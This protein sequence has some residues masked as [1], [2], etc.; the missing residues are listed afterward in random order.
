LDESLLRQEIVGNNPRQ[1]SLP[2]ALWTRA[3]VQMAIKLR[4]NIDMPI[5]TVGEYLRR[6]A[7]TPQRPIKRA[8]AQRPAELRAWLDDIYPGV[9]KRA[10]AEGAEIYWADETAIKSVSRNSFRR[11]APEFDTNRCK[12]LIRIAPTPRRATTTSSS[13]GLESVS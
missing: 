4:F 5:R 12:S 2:F 9:V 1:M 8:V 6:W 11:S 3:A 10:K 13:A 7:F